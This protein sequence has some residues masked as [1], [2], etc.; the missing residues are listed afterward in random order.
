MAAS[1]DQDVIAGAVIFNIFYG[2]LYECRELEIRFI[3]CFAASDDEML[4]EEAFGFT[5]PLFGEDHGF[6]FVGG[7]AD[8]TAFIKSVKRA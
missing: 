4:L 3:I 7:V 5:Q 1:A 8:E 6:R 2:M